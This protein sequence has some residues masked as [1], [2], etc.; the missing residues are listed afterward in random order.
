MNARRRDDLLAALAGARPGAWRGLDAALAALD[1]AAEPAA[2][3]TVGLPADA[4]AGALEL[5]A[6]ARPDA[7]LAACARAL[8]LAPPPSAGAAGL[9]LR[10]DARAGAPAELALLGP[11][12]ARRS[13]TLLARAGAGAREE[14]SAPL[15]R[16]RFALPEL[17]ARIAAL[18]ARCPVAA[19]RVE[20]APG[21]DGRLAPGERWSLDFAAPE[22]WPRFLRLDASAPF[23]A[24]AATLTALLPGCAARSLGWRGE[25]AWLEVSG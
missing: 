5:G 10:W 11:A 15:S 22:P 23:S 25:A 7:D 19:V 12:R 21:A 4:A 18:D 6:S 14:R 24:E 16:A 1:A 8:G 13:V 9:R 20:W 17:A 3:W 2:L